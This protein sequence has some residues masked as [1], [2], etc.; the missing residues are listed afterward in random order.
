MF[1]EMG[2]LLHSTGALK[3]APKGAAPR[4]KTPTRSSSRRTPPPRGE[5]LGEASGSSRR[6][7]PPRGEKRPDSRKRPRMESPPRH[8]HRRGDRPRPKDAPRES[9]SHRAGP[10]RVPKP[11]PKPGEKRFVERSLESLYAKC[12]SMKEEIRLLKEEK[13]NRDQE[14]E[15]LGE[16]LNS[17]KIEQVNF[18][19]EMREFREQTLLQAK[20]ASEK[21]TPAQEDTLLERAGPGKLFDSHFHINRMEKWGIPW[22]SLS[23]CQTLAGGVV[24]FCDPIEFPSE[25]FLSTLKQN[26]LNILVAVGIHPEHAATHPYI[27][28]EALARMRILKETGQVHA[29][30]EMGLDFSKRVSIQSQEILLADQL[31]LVA[32]LPLVLHI[33]GSQRDQS[34]NNALKHCLSFLKG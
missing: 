27:L 19:K 8:S 34:S 25:E 17:L 11:V 5:K 3:E 6:S 24:V 26:P 4:E 12:G 14:M 23:K 21:L 22:E 15:E 13:R 16:E 29:I 31:P 32:P 9:Y 10:P 2:R 18:F 30:G 1:E 7:P 28:R 20:G 33:R